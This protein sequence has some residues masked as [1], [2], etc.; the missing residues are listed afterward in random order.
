[1]AGDLNFTST[2]TFNSGILTQGG[3]P[4]V[5]NG[6]TLIKSQFNVNGS[7][8]GT[9]AITFSTITFTLGAPDLNIPKS[10]QLDEMFKFPVPTVETALEMEP[11]L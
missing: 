7:I 4:I 5:F 2:F 8:A 10:I 9:G 3:W 1:M 11:L 6:A